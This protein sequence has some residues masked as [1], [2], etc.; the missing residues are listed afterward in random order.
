M[1]KKNLSVTLAGI[2]VIRARQDD[3]QGPS[4]GYAKKLQLENAAEESVGSVHTPSQ[5]E[6][7]TEG[8]RGL[9]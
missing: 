6:N 8:E 7:C 9:V 5:P 1:S 4:F 3:L 2:V